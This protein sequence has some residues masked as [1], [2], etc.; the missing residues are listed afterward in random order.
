MMEHFHILVTTT[1]YIWYSLNV[2]ITKAVI[3]KCTH[4]II[5]TTLLAV[6][7]TLER[8]LKFLDIIH[9]SNF[10]LVP[11]LELNI[12]W[13]VNV[14]VA[15][16]SMSNV[17]SCCW[18]AKCVPSLC[19]CLQLQRRVIQY[20]VV[21]QS[22]ALNVNWLWSSIIGCSYVYKMYREVP[23]IMNSMFQPLYG[24]QDIVLCQ[25]IEQFLQA[26]LH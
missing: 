20:C 24:I 13:T 23:S 21:S 8:S 15:Q 17:G 5:F 11:C 12:E 6:R 19:Q 14:V 18:C 7:Y 10:C 1:Q 25:I 4:Q 2:S 16:F 3:K 9:S 26:A 22:W